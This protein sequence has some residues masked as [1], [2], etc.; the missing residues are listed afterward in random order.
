MCGCCFASPFGWVVDG[1]DTVRKAIREE[2][3]RGASFIKFTGSG[4]VSTT[5]DP[6]EAIQFSEEEVRAIVEEVEN[7]LTYCTAHIHPDA[8]LKRAI[9]LGV[10][11]IEH[12]TLIEP[13]TAQMAAEAGTK[14]VPTLAVIAALADHGADLGY[15]RESLAKLEKVK[16][17]AVIRLGHMKRAGVRVGFGSDLIGADLQKRQCTEFTLRTPV[18]S[19]FEILSQATAVNAAIIGAQGEIGEIIAGA[20][21][22]IIVVDGNPLEDLKV[23]AA[24]GAHVSAIMKG[25]AFHRNRLDS[26]A[27]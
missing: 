11:C 16:D 13:D 8:A 4:G 23:L 15:P 22:D 17:E 3:R 18:Y 2:L 27:R 20:Y 25:G 1:V 14:I 24:D 19:N 7:H 12:G 10:H 26:A 6:L 21:A 5:S 9:R